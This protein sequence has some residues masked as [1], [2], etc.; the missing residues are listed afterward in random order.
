MTE[1]LLMADLRRANVVLR[2]L[3]AMGLAIAIDDFGTGYSSLAYL[4]KFPAQTLKIDR[5]FV[6][7]L[8]GDLDDMAITRAV[9]AMGHSL[10]MRVVAEGVE[11]AEQQAFLHGIGCDALQGY[12]FGRPIPGAE[13]AKRL[14]RRA[15]F[16]TALQA[17]RSL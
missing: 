14:P 11:T 6:S 8:P 9:V 10:G 3:N 17:V 16:E 13:I 1:S 12:R 15:V 5:S 4:K 2:E 7:D